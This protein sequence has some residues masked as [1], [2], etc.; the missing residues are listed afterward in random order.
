MFYNEQHHISVDTTRT[1]INLTDKKSNCLQI[2]EHSAKHDH[3]LVR[4]LIKRNSLLNDMIK[5]EDFTFG[6][7][8]IR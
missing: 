8:I 3:F 6:G 1:A 5:N 7:Q 4:S 2:L